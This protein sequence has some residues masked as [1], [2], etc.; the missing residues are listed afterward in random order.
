M[1]FTK[2][3]KW[4]KYFL[5]PSADVNTLLQQAFP[6]ARGKYN[7]GTIVC[8]NDQIITKYAVGFMLAVLD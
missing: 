5:A 3:K 7:Y 2:N 6:E 8:Q 4:K 1:N